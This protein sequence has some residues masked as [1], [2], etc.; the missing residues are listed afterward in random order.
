M[1]LKIRHFFDQRFVP[2]LFIKA[3]YGLSERWVDSLRRDLKKRN[4]DEI[5]FHHTRMR[6]GQLSRRDDPVLRKKDIDIDRPWTVPLG[7]SAP[8]LLF[9][10]LD[11]RQELG[12]LQ[13][14]AHFNDLVT[15]PG[16]GGIA[17]R[18]GAVERRGPQDLHSRL[19]QP[20]Q[21]AAQMR[22]PIA[23]VAAK[24]QE[25]ADRFF[26]RIDYPS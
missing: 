8:Q 7:G 16:L 21:R 20:C 9:Y 15:E 12:W 10:F 2:G 22:T 23:Q 26:S 4:E 1:I 3:G 19:F 13:I 18:L 25:V 17:D 24:T 11:E 6:N 5:P 14:R